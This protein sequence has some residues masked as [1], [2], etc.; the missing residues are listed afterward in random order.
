MPKPEVFGL[1]RR[2]A[3][4]AALLLPLA[5]CV[6]D[7]GVP[8]AVAVANGAAVVFPAAGARNVNPDTQLRLTF[9]SQPEIGTSGLIRIYDAADNTLVD[10]LDMSIASSPNPNGRS[11]A[12]NEAE[13]RAQAA[14][15]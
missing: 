13:R 6:M 3:V 5:A 10:T 4:L 12:A 2:L 15:T 14:A 7:S 1:S 11:T 8:S 9:S